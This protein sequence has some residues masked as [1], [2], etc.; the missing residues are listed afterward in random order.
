M[1]TILGSGGAIGS[2]LA[3]ELIKY[4]DKIR[5]VARNPQKVNDTDELF[6]ADLTN[7][8]ELLKS[9]ERSEVE[10]LC[11]GLTYQLKVW[12]QQWLAVAFTFINRKI[13][14]CRFYQYD[15]SR[16]EGKACL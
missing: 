16:N 12:Q 13:N 10:Y 11:V 9:V 8:G 15:C 6:K 5:L 3:K 14:R 2:V 1:Q 4:T 7:A